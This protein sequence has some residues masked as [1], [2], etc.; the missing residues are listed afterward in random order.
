MVLHPHD[1]AVIGSSLLSEL[2]EAAGNAN[3]QRCEE[4]QRQLDDLRAWRD[5]AVEELADYRKLRGAVAM[6]LDMGGVYDERSK[7]IRPRA[8]PGAGSP[9]DLRKPTPLEQE[10]LECAK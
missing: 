7:R 5:K 8:W 6:T 3:C 4:T 1:P 9:R 2:N 10:G